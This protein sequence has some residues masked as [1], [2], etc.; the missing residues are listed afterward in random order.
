MTKKT[1]PAAQVS[2]FIAAARAAGCDD[3]EKA[4]EKRLKAVASAP[5]PMPATKPKTKKPA[6]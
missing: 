4:F 2:K 5:P 3:D 1:A 6:K